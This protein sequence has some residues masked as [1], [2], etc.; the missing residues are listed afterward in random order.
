MPMPDWLRHRRGKPE[1]TEEAALA[2]FTPLERG[3]EDLMRGALVG[4]P[5]TLRQ[6]LAEYEEAG[7]QELVV[8]FV[9]APKS[10]DCLRLFAREFVSER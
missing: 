5:K 8:R 4:T 3:D 1:E 6:R 2:K 9:D 10:R 7:I